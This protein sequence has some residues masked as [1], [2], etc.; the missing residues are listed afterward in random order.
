MAKPGKLC[1]RGHN[2]WYYVRTTEAR[3][4]KTG[5]RQERYCR[6]C[7]ALTQR[8]RRG[9]VVP[10]LDPPKLTREQE[11]EQL[12]RTQYDD[13]SYKRRPWT[14]AEVPFEYEKIV[15]RADMEIA[16]VNYRAKHEHDPA[17]E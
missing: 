17:W 9:G 12:A 4:L 3:Y 1:R 2:N 14:K 15:F 6:T 8:R 16:E 11:I 13:S 7:N 10:E 5:N